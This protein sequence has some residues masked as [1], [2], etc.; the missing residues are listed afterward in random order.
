MHSNRVQKYVQ[1]LPGTLL[2]EISLRCHVTL[3]FISDIETVHLFCAKKLE[4]VLGY[5]LK[6]V[7]TNQLRPIF[8]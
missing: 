8:S 1:I 3:V 4:S 2:S 6:L 5:N 7:W